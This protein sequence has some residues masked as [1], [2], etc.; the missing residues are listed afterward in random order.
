MR[1]RTVCPCP[2]PLPSQPRSLTCEPLLRHCYQ[3]AALAGLVVAAGAVHPAG[4]APQTPWLTWTR[5]MS[6]RWVC[7]ASAGQVAAAGHQAARAAAA[8]L[9]ASQAAL[10]VGHQEQLQLQMAKRR[11]LAL[12]RGAAAARVARPGALAAAAAAMAAADPASQAAPALGAEA[13]LPAMR[14]SQRQAKAAAAMAAHHQQQQASRW[15]PAVAGLAAVWA[16]QAV[17]EEATRVAEVAYP[18]AEQALEAL[19]TLQG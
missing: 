14:T 10:A 13:E 12:Q 11:R 7:V 19:A 9:V 1:T 8:C 15:H 2:F 3:L 6:Q 18:A 16:G 4:V 5:R 17:R